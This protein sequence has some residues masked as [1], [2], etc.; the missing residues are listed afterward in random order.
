MSDGLTKK[1]YYKGRTL[2]SIRK[3][4]AYSG[5]NRQFKIE[6]KNKI[7]F[8]NLIHIA[9]RKKKFGWIEGLNGKRGDWWMLF[10]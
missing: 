7:L 1:I 4:R 10:G 2:S 9:N 3:P 6:R 5:I 8:D